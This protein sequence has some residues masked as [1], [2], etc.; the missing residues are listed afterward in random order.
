[1]LVAQ[2]GTRLEVHLVAR[3]GIEAHTVVIGASGRCDGLVVKHHVVGYVGGGR[4]IHSVVKV[5]EQR[6]ACGHG[7]RAKEWRLPTSWHNHLGGAQRNE[8]VR[9]A[10]GIA[11]RSLLQPRNVSAI[12]LVGGAVQFGLAGASPVGIVVPVVVVGQLVGPRHIL[13]YD[14]QRDVGSALA[15]VGRAGV[16]CDIVVLHFERVVVALVQFD[17]RSLGRCQ[18][19]R[20]VA[21]GGLYGGV[22]HSAKALANVGRVERVVGGAQYEL[23]RGSAGIVRD[24][25]QVVQFGADGALRVGIAVYGHTQVVASSLE[26]GHLVEV[27][28]QVARGVCPF[29]GI[30]DRGEAQ[31]EH[32]SVVGECGRGFERIAANGEVLYRHGARF[33]VLSGKWNERN[34]DNAVA[35]GR[36]VEGRLEGVACQQIELLFILIDAVAWH[37]LHILLQQRGVGLGVAAL[38]GLQGGVVGVF[39]TEVDKGGVEAAHCLEFGC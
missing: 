3:V 26:G 16:L 20:Q 37:A 24:K 36:Q 1:M 32:R 5:G 21:C 12:I 39:G 25:L 6:V 15:G 31:V 7:V 2:F 35:I 11:A 4:R 38:G 30:G 22:L 10:A 17:A 8:S 13:G 14:L 23:C 9:C 29:V 34:L 33:G 19:E 18:I 28:T 27:E